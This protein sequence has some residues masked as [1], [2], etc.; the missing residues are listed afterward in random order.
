MMLT[1]TPEAIAAQA[2]ERLDALD[3]DLSSGLFG[4]ATFSVVDNDGT[5]RDVQLPPHIGLELLDNARGL[6]KRD[7]ASLAVLNGNPNSSAQQDD[8]NPS[9]RSLFDR[10][11][12]ERKPGISTINNYD[13]SLRAFERKHG[14]LRIKDL[15]P[16][17]VRQ[18]K[19]DL[20]TAG[21]KPATI[22]K[23][24]TALRAITRYAKANDFIAIDP[25]AAIKLV[26]AIRHVH[27]HWQANA[28]RHR[29]RGA[30]RARDDVGAAARGYRQ[31][32]G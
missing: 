24:L 23:H 28:E 15:T 20:V 4:G 27:C 25:A 17:H 16:A 2:T 7:R 29:L 14:E 11:K 18:F 6:A 5:Q 21:G 13:T 8:Q 9:M 12:R 1:G 32:Q 30:I 22:N 26:A 19:D 10:W 3:E 31:S